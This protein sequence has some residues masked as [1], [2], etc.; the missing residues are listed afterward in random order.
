MPITLMYITNNIKIAE[1][2]Q[3]SGV[4]R[5]W[6]D[7]EY[8]GKEQRQKGMNTV[9]SH[10]SIDDIKKLRPYINTSKLMVRTNPINPN[11]KKE[12]NES[13]GA[14]ADYMMLPMFKT[15]DEVE[16]FIDLVAGRAKTMLLVET[17]ESVN[18]LNNILKVPGIDEVH[19]GLN[20]LHIAYNKK[21]MFELLADGTVERIIT[22]IKEYHYPYGF[23]GIARIGYG[24]LPAELILREHYRLGSEMAILSR[25]F[26]NANQGI[27][28]DEIQKVF[29]QGVN[30]IRNEE[31]KILQ[32]DSDM[33]ER[34]RIIICKKIKEILGEK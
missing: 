3:E 32:M 26:C 4:D 1:I 6:I 23:G 29:K 14:G 19:I 18:E 28:I 2:A 30:D 31:K 16:E 15:R 11:S 17:K 12:I 5:I 20:D 9:K 24:I 21:F 22:T 8:I 13:I 25:S 34:N 33:L 27:N 10:H 7:L